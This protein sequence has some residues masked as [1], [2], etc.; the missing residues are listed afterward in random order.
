MQSFSNFNDK[1]ETELASSMIPPVN[2][3]RRASYKLRTRVVASVFLICLAVDGCATKAMGEPDSAQ[4]SFAE[5]AGLSGCRVTQ[6]MD[7]NEVARVN[8]RLEI[9]SLMAGDLAWHRFLEKKTEG[10]E[11]R[12]VSCKST[13][14]YF[15][16]LFSGHAVAGR[17][18]L[19][20]I[21]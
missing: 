5:E 19:P 7:E 13:G 1:V 10:V 17:Y 9:S 15:Y 3:D 18:D 20:T 11:L 21:D 14:A 2:P 16:A 12:L 6:P 4:G 8:G